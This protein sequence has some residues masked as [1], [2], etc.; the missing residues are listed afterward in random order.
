MVNHI[1]SYISPLVLLMSLSACDF[2][3]QVGSLIDDNLP[4]CKLDEKAIQPCKAPLS[5]YVYEKEFNNRLLEQTDFSA[6][7]LSASTLASPLVNGWLSQS[8]TVTASDPNLIA[9][10]IAT[11]I[12]VFGVAGS[13]D[14]AAIPSP[15]NE[16]I[17]AADCTAS[18]NAYAYDVEFDG[19]S[20]VCS[21][22]GNGA[23]NS[24][25]WV[26]QAAVISETGQVA[27]SPCSSGLIGA[28]CRAQQSGYVYDQVSGGRTKNCVASG[29][30]SDPCWLTIPS[31]QQRVVVEGGV[32]CQSGNNNLS[33][34]TNPNSFVYDI[35]FGGRS[36]VCDAG[37]DG[38]CFLGQSSKS[39]LDGA[40]NKENIKEGEII[41]GILGE[42]AG[43]GGW[44][45]GMHR[46]RVVK[47]IRLQTETGMYAG[48]KSKALPN[49]YRPIPKI[50]S[51]DEGLL[52]P[53]LAPVNRETWGSKSCGQSGTL[54]ARIT[55]CA[56]TIGFS[57]Q[58]N[59]VFEGNASQGSWKLVSRLG[60]KANQQA[61]E[62]WIDERAGLLWS[63]QVSQ[64]S[65]W[66]H[67][68]GLSNSSEG[69]LNANYKE[70]DPS[71]ICDNPSFQINDNKPIS[72]CKEVLADNNFGSNY[73]ANA[74]GGLQQ[75]GTPSV[76]WRLPSLNDYETAEYNGIRYI[77]P[78]IGA[79]GGIDEWTATVV[80]ND[81]SKA[82][83][84]NGRQGLHSNQDRR[85]PSAVRCI[86]R[87]GS[88]E[89]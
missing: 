5:S 78:D 88:Y 49:G 28:E 38:N 76:H 74:K 84:Y 32:K 87:A 56:N 4:E 29:S 34:I 11:G 22:L 25:C 69:G 80:A 2:S 47:A 15:C 8:R 63:S 77:L 82:W 50:L 66:C 61:Q 72:L 67:A 44:S 52:N 59:G 1:I 85:L 16:G 30:N 40:L 86:G 55:D 64:S 89:P 35:L 62:V 6:I 19:R 51:D 41:F 39:G 7:V 3:F 24:Q 83:I 65:N 54:L 36:S 48:D 18:V 33:C 37:P 17:N 81:R 20:T 26:P 14:R 57:A 58:W 45:S 21:N 10:N 9:T 27:L 73:F 12:N 46:N 53:D 75:A 23:L 13:F 31:G 43:E 42:F 70:D 71:D 79:Q 60:P 68:S